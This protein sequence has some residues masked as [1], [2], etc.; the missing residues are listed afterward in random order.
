MSGA[1]AQATDAVDSLHELL[2]GRFGSEKS[3]RAGF[4]FDGATGDPLLIDEQL[5]SGFEVPFLRELKLID[6]EVRH[7]DSLEQETVQHG[8]G[9]LP[10]SERLQAEFLLDP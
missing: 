3:R 1:P 2:A 6:E 7:E 10:T 5:E 9:T 4:D 8:S